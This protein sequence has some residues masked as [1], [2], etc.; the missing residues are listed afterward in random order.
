[1]FS[2]RRARALTSAAV[3]VAALSLGVLPAL[4]STASEEQQGAALAKALNA[5]DRSCGSLSATDFE[6]IGEYAMGLN[7]ATVAQHAAMNAHM[8]AMIGA[9]GEERAHRAMGRAYAGCGTAAQR[10]GTYGPGMMGGGYGSGMM[11]GTAYGPGMMNRDGTGAGAA[12]LGNARSAGGHHDWSAGAVVGIA[13]L[14]AALAGG[15]V[16]LL[17]TRR[18]RHRPAAVS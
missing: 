6:R 14:A 15:L 2:W 11:G 7:F 9:G 18:G 8:R 16:A 12:R 5:G 1:M 17:V 10:S 4:A 3:A 13:V